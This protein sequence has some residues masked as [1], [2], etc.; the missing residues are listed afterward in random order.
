MKLDASVLR[1]LT[2]DDFRVLTAI[3]MGQKN[4]QI[5]PVVLIETISNVKRANVQKI[6]SNLLK[7]KLIAHNGKKYDGYKL[8][9]NG[10]DF[11]ALRVF[12]ARGH[13]EGVGM[14]MG[15]GKES[16]IH[17]CQ[18]TGGRVMCLKLHRLGRV[19]FRSI[20][21]NRDY[22]NG[23]SSASWQYLARLAAKKEFA[24][25]TALREHGFPVPVAV[26][27]NR[28][29]ILMEFIN[30][31]PLY[32]VRALKH[33]MMVLEKLMRLLVRLVAAGLIHGD[34][35]EFNLMINSDDEITMIDFP[36]VVDVNHPNAS[37]YFDRDVQCIRV[38]F[39]RR[40][41]IEVNRF[42][43]LE[44]AIASSKRKEARMEEFDMPAKPIRVNTISTE[45]EKM[46][47]AC[48]EDQR[49]DGVECENR[50]THLVVVDSDEED[51]DKCLEDLEREMVEENS[52]ADAENCNSD[53]ETPQLI[54]MDEIANML[55]LNKEYTSLK[56]VDAIS[57]DGL[58]P[59][60]EDWKTKRTICEDDMSSENSGS[61]DESDEELTTDQ[62]GTV[63]VK[64][65]RRERKKPQVRQVASAEAVKKQLQRQRHTA[66]PNTSKTKDRKQKKALNELRDYMRDF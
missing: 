3:E 16:D 23:R 39:E 48:I 40:F 57:E 19:S 11:L 64:I 45:E 34:F 44:D 10:Y 8:T 62:V 35:N 9:Y 6:L 7:H 18:G 36:Q 61:S 49:T 28:H 42:P 12:V 2:K 17:I 21:N 54:S 63:D 33:P 52:E 5:V 51:V 22:L 59:I 29:A 13:L 25:L 46:L 65:R 1:Y 47:G 32:Q 31:T 24:Y 66:R 41:G 4:H 60:E 20:K 38:F 53:E 14:R 15:V 27:H 55:T 30:A 56:P 58:A 37:M 50:E 43:T 26:D